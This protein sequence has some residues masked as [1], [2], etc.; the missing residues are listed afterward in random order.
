M[1]K[2]SLDKKGEES[3]PSTKKTKLK[4]SDQI[5]MA[6]IKSS[7][8][9]VTSP[10]PSSP[11]KSKKLNHTSN[12]INKESLGKTVLSADKLQVA[13]SQPK[14]TMTQDCLDNTPIGKK[15]V[16]KIRKKRVKA[17]SANKTS[18]NEAIVTRNNV[19]NLCLEDQARHENLRENDLW[20]SKREAKITLQDVRTTLGRAKQNG[21]QKNVV[22]KADEAKCEARP[23]TNEDNLVKAI[24]SVH[25]GVPSQ[26]IAVKSEK[27]EVIL[28]KAD[29]FLSKLSKI[30]NKDCVF[31]Q[32]ANSLKDGLKMDHHTM[33]L[34]SL[35]CPKRRFFEAEISSR[36]DLLPL[37]K[38]NVE[39]VGDGGRTVMERMDVRRP[40]AGEVGTRGILTQ[41]QLGQVTLR[42][43]PHWLV[44][45]SPQRPRDVLEMAQKG[46]HWYYQRYIDVKRGG[47]GGVAMLLA[48]YCVLS[49]IWSYPHLKRDRWRKYH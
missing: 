13:K 6:A 35:S 23:N 21:C 30:E 18:S 37:F 22:E 38:Q 29:I 39:R 46:W 20:T 12:Q 8:A 10:L 48:G 44:S 43:L 15:T 5:K 36:R 40:N 7:A 26:V 45:R 47:I 33:G 4:L 24:V 42:E 14:S 25:E 41:Q 2:L 49:Y 11:L 28:S 1:Q 32:R 9:S 27:S 17:F 16:E 34:M 3:L 19:N 31:T